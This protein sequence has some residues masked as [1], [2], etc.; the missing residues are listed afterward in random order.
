MAPIS[1]SFS[2]P[3]EKAAKKQEEERKDID[4]G[5]ERKA[6]RVCV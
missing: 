1:S 4:F 6:A 3:G 5:G 2:Y